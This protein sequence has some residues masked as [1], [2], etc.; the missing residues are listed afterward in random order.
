[1]KILL[2]GKSDFSYNRTRVLIKGLEQS[3]GVELVYYPIK[4]GISFN[5]EEFTELSKSCDIV[6]IPPFRHSDV[7]FIQR[8]SACPVVFDALISKYLT[9]TIDHGKWWTALGKTLRD[10]VAFKN[11]D[12]IL[13]DTEAH[14]QYI[15]DRYSLTGQS[16]LTLPVGVDV[17]LFAP[18][19]ED[20]SDIFKVGFYGGFIP[21]QGVDRIIEAAN[22][23]RGHSD[24]RFE[25][26]GKGPRFNQMKALASKL[27]VDNLD[28][29]GWVS[30]LGLNEKINS[31]DLCM[32]IFGDSLKTDLVVPNKV[33]HYAAL[34]KCI[35]T[36]NTE[37]INEVFEDNQ[38]I[39]LTSN[40]PVDIAAAILDLKENKS[41]RS[42]IAKNG[43]KLIQNSYNQKAIADVFLSFFRK[44]LKIN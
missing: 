25:L 10:R 30:Y 24:I 44:E 18:L 5:S 27:K 20:E 32:G 15:V 39:V 16:V 43:F 2:T 34:R 41:R 33:Y 7:K 37:A 36:K 11:S 14:K 42:E 35:I 21:L 1:M 12:Y 4:K 31:F 17:D 23:L 13:M 40:D 38:N 29:L 6:Y 9:R 28:F 19:S 8:R 3:E 22:L 26:I